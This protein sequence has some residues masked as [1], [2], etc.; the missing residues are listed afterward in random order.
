[1]T[2]LT[3]NMSGEFSRKCRLNLIVR[4]LMKRAPE[5]HDSVIGSLIPDADGL[6][7]ELSAAYV[8]ESDGRPGILPGK[9]YSQT[10]RLR[11]TGL[12]SREAVLPAATGTILDAKIT[13]DTASYD[14]MLR[15][16]SWQILCSPKDT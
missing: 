16:R 3:V 12:L 13:V 10:V 2:L 9:G 15:V 8:H 7:I 11:F 4:H 5:F 6:T 1:V 14:N